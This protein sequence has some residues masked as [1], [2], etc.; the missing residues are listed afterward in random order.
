MYTARTIIK[1]IL[2]LAISGLFVWAAFFA[3]AWGKTYFENQQESAYNDAPFELK[4]KAKPEDVIYSQTYK[5]ASG[6]DEVKYA[7]LAGEVVLMP[8][9]DIHRRTPTSQTEILEQ[10]KDE[11][12]KPMEKLHT[13]FISKPQFYQ[14][15]GKWRQIEYATTTSEVFSMSGAIPYIERRELADSLFPGER[16]FA[17]VSTFYPDANVE[18]SSVDGQVTDVETAVDSL[19]VSFA[20]T[21][22]WDNAYAGAGNAFTD[23]ATSLVM[24]V[25]SGTFFNGTDYECSKS[26]AR[27]IVL[28]NTASLPD[29]A[30]ISA[31][32]LK[33]YVA[34]K[35]NG[36]N[37]GSDTVNIISS[38]PA[39]N[40]ALASSD[41][42]SFGSTLYASAVDITSITT[43][44]YLTMALN[45]SGIAAVS[46]TGV[47]KF[48]VKEGHDY[49]GTQTSNISNSRVT[50]S[51]ADTS[52]TSQDPTL[53]VT[54]TV[55]SFSVGSWFPF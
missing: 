45:S 33:L 39:S 25:S 52:G 36:I 7:Y 22:A 50:F 3:F 17:T 16:A 47:T 26:L 53:D 12:G 15:K 31:V 34:S 42:T 46:K 6:T 44:A 54:Y 18:T 9:E 48:G 19:D 10:Y 2:I 8:H 51:A 14:S 27:P 38:N 29:T 32:N 43:S 21:L 4:L 1:K 41:Y 49:A 28:F 37:D 11:K 55:S 5:T 35:N 40:T 23:S 24:E 20:C 13:T 30:V